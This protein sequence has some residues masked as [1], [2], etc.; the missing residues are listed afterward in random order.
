MLTGSEPAML[1]SSP[2]SSFFRQGPSAFYP[3]TYVVLGHLRHAFLLMDE[4]SSSPV[5]GYRFVPTK[6]VEPNPSSLATTTRL[7]RDHSIGFPDRTTFIA[8][9]FQSIV[10][11]FGPQL[12]KR[13]CRRLVR[14]P[15]GITGSPRH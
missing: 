6:F 8:G 4:P 5:C 14:V 2:C 1:S 3:L 11:D 15:F 10:R 7:P 13:R 9:A 12:L